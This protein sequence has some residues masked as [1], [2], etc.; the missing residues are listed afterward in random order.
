MVAR[1]CTVYTFQRPF[2]SR[3]NRRIYLVRAALVTRAGNS[4]QVKRCV[5]QSGILFCQPTE[6][7]EMDLSREA[8]ARPA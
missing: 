5:E 7:V 4:A 2:S 1:R 8:G 6:H 3:L